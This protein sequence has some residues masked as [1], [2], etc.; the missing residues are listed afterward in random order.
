MHKYIL[1]ALLVTFVRPGFGQCLHPAASPAAA[2]QPAPASPFPLKQ[3]EQNSHNGTQ[4][5]LVK[6]QM[7]EV[8]LTKLASVSSERYGGSKGMSA[9]ELLAKLESTGGVNR[10]SAPDLSKLAGLIEAL[11]KDSLAS[12]LRSRRC[13]SSRKNPPIALWEA[14]LATE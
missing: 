4:F 10:S 14:K 1:A 2:P 11:R 3:T 13:L 6:L 7:I 8:S 12:R 9:L 5:I